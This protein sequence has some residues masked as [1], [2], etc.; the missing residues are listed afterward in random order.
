MLH[1][2][3]ASINGE[4]RPPRPCK[5]VTF[6]EDIKDNEDRGLCNGTRAFTLL[7]TTF[8]TL[9]ILFL[10]IALTVFGANSSLIDFLLIGPIFVIV[11]ML[12][13]IIALRLC[14]RPFFQ[15]RK[16]RAIIEERVKRIK[17]LNI[18][19]FVES[20]SSGIVNPIQCGRMLNDADIISQ[21]TG[22]TQVRK[23]SFIAE[24]PEERA[25][26]QESPISN[27]FQVVQPPTPYRHFTSNNEI[28]SNTLIMETNSI[29]T[30]HKEDVCC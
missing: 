9:G 23:L 17:D 13:S 1:T 26:T 25:E 28:T 30:P 4:Q 2:A 29:N 3:D 10:G 27:A 24:S 8:L 16:I 12:F 5:R 19:G 22:F 11:G 6:H 15:K 21:D 14:L 20:Q 7:C 18:E